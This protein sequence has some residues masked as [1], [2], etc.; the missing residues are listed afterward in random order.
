[1]LVLALTV[2]VAQAHASPDPS[3]TIH[4]ARD[5]VE[6]VA[7]QPRR[8]IE[9]IVACVH[10][11]P[12]GSA[13]CDPPESTCGNGRRYYHPDDDWRPDVPVPVSFCSPGSGVF[14]TDEPR[15]PDTGSAPVASR[16]V[17][18]DAPTDRS[19]VTAPTFGDAPE[20]RVEAA[21]G[22]AP[23][24]TPGTDPVSPWIV[25]AALVGA[26][27][28]LFLYRRLTRDGLLE[29]EIRRTVHETVGDE[30]GRTA[31]EIAEAADLHYT[32]VRY[33][34]EI[35]EEFD[36]IVARRDGR[37]IRY[38]LDH[39]RYGRIHRRVLAAAADD[40][41]HRIL[42]MLARDGPLRSG[43]LADRVGV[44]PSTASH[45]LARLDEV[46][47]VDRTRRDNEVHYDLPD[48]IAGVVRRVLG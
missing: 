38:F 11:P 3:H 10:D 21:A 15:A 5:D 16:T 26:P 41:R 9:Q 40:S 6:D 4:H 18:Q 30:P 28:L 32:T 37:R 24:A 25:A 22:G 1:M 14:P 29:N 45:H 44:A 36:E 23:P 39:G 20:R 7:D 48:R 13:R 47:L 19:P 2:P 31:A 12:T 43:D 8:S 46:D 17:L 33:H 42:T 27:L 35:L 34:L